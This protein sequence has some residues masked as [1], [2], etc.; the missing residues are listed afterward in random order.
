MEIKLIAKKY[1][2]YVFSFFM[3]LL[4]S[5]IMSLVISIFNVGVVED[6]LSIW[7]KAWGFAFIVAFPTV[8]FVSPIV[9][10]LVNLV[11]ENDQENS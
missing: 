3:A 4:M 5:C 8:T 7:L 9:R 10:R 1:T 6:I 11:I 2:P